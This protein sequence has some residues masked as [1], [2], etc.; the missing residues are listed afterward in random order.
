MKDL[1]LKS[2]MTVCGKGGKLVRQQLQ[3]D[4]LQ[5]CRGVARGGHCVFALQ[6]NIKQ[7]LCSSHFPLTH[8]KSWWWDSSCGSLAL[9]MASPPQISPGVSG[10]PC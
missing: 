3:A 4:C 5:V 10:L 1:S 6:Y 7:L 2:A 8:C 9:P